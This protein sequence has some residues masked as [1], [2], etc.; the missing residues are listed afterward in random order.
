MSKPTFYLTLTAIG[1]AGTPGA[2]GRFLRSGSTLLDDA[3]GRAEER[4][5]M[6]VC[7]GECRAGDQSSQIRAS[8][9]RSEG[10]AGFGKK[11]FDAPNT[12]IRQPSTVYST[13][14]R[15]W[16]VLVSAPSRT[17]HIHKT[18]PRGIPTQW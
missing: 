2:A 13:A 9:G 4:R 11:C 3:Y 5:R 12:Q 10:L 7:G 15:H 1:V 6:A 16:Q 14:T 8:R 17:G 18:E